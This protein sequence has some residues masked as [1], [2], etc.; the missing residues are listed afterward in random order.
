MVDLVDTDGREADRGGD[1]VAEER[2][3]G[4]A[5]VSVDE[6]LGDDAVPGE[7]GAVG[8]VRLGE[9]CVLWTRTGGERY[10]RPR[11]GDEG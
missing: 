6:L 7:G 4:V 5:A 10:Q 9:A 3:G 2:G 11:P 1:L 8:G